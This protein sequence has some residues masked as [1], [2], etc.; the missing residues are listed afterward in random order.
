MQMD[1]FDDDDFMCGDDE[2][3]LDSY[4]G[5]QQTSPFTT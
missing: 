5:R 3:T 4:Q 2:M 1:L